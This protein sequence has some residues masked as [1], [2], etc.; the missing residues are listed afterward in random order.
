MQRRKATRRKGIMFA[1]FLVC[2]LGASLM[3]AAMAT[4]NWFEAACVMIDVSPNNGNINFGLFQGSR[5]FT[6]VTSRY[7]TLKVVCADGDCMY[8]CA[9][10]KEHREEQLW[11]VKNGTVK[12]LT[13]HCPDGVNVLAHPSPRLSPLSEL[14]FGESSHSSWSFLF[15]K[16][17]DTD[18][19]GRR[20][21]FPLSMALKGE[22]KVSSQVVESSRSDL[23]NEKML[24]A[25]VAAIT[26]DD[27][28]VAREIFID[29]NT[30][31]WNSI[32]STVTEST[33]TES[34][35]TESTTTESTSTTPA[36]KVNSVFM[37]YGLW[38]GTIVCLSLGMVFAVVG[39]LFAVINTAT[40]PVEAITGVPGL[41]LWNGL[42]ALF[43]L[44]CVILWA[45]QYHKYL[46][47]NVLLYDAV[48]G[49]TTENN[50][51]F[52][53]SY[54][55]V[56]VAIFVHVVNIGIIFMGTYEPKIKEQ[57][58]AP[59]PKGGNIMLY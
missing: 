20:W 38:V 8:S 46:T 26:N 13:K 23:S 51:V 47:H 15:P 28:S 37:N 39:A 9:D 7:H 5:T 30:T 24:Q 2:C 43:N 36:V 58:Q 29:E 10:T 11:L 55:L 3:A 35:T 56:V 1:S 40:T 41:Y 32:E 48:D 52:G 53:Y 6:G 4:N 19:M 22:T 18:L 31:D 45:V 34:T 42:A 50:E 54:W 16:F 12:G 25:R 21:Y 44:I 17:L 59:D 14:S 57:L 49:W 33:T 27:A